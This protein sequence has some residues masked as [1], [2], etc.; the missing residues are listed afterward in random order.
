MSGYVF[1]SNGNKPSE[2]QRQ[3]RD[4]IKL[5]NVNRPCLKTALDM[6]Y[7]V[8]FGV[9]RS[10]PEKLKCELPV[11]L[12]DSHTYRS[13]TNF[14][15]NLIA[16]NNLKEVVENNNIEVIHC[17]TPIGGMI[18]RLIGKRYK[19]DKVIYTAHGFHF[20]K[21]APILNRTVF[22]LA[23]KLMAR[24]TDAIITMNEE[25]YQAAKK[26]KLKKNGKIFKVHG[27]GINLNDFNN[28]VVDLYSKRKELGFYEEDIL[29]ISAGDLVKRKNYESAIKAIAKSKN[30]KIH[31]LICG[32]GPE[33]EN[34]QELAR[35]LDVEDRIHFLGFRNDI[36]ELMKISDIFLFTTLQEGLPRSMMEAM[37]TGLPCIASNIRG[38]VD[39]I[40]DSKGGFLCDS[41]DVKKISE[42]INYLADNKNLRKKMG[43]YNLKEIRD[44]DILFV[45]NEIRDIYSEVLEKNK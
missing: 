33:K 16:Y 15:D 29:C 39:L 24:W 9:N 10:N 27:V 30:E 11:T 21:G 4:N 42:K 28:V 14:K 45:E 43:N 34:L 31:Y 5:S 20:Y 35:E 26:F 17:N 41:S 32:R 22:K 8:F 2:E 1:I 25:D 3:S 38:N 36:K 23:E 7:K 13:I 12:Y 19:I 6:G 18:G 44:Y 40:R 37:A